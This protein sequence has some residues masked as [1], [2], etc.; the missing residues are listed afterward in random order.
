VK[1]GKALNVKKMIV[2]SVG[3]LGRKY[4][5][6]LRAVDVEKE[7]VECS[8]KGE[9]EVRVEDIPSLV[10]PVVQRV[11]VCLGSKSGSPETFIIQEVPAGVTFLKVNEQGYGEYKN[12]IDGSMMIYIPRNT[13]GYFIDKYEVSN[14]QYKKFCDKTGRTYPDAPWVRRY[15]ENYPDNPA[16]NITCEDASDYASWA[17]KRLPTE[18]EWKYAAMGKNGRVYPWGN[19]WDASKCNASGSFDGYPKTSPV[20]SY[21]QGGSPFGVMDMLGNVWEWTE[22]RVRR[23]GGWVSKQPECETCSAS[24]TELVDCQG[25]RCVRNIK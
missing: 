10:P 7:N 19:E 23:G 3:K 17:G 5:V 15:L 14:E 11:S 8:D 24:W 16:V 4:F 12:E 21:P 6:F 22:D 13:K 20:G 9:G 2:G 1:I 18:A 25:F